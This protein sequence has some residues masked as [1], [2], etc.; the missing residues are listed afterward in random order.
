MMN[1]LLL[2]TAN[3]HRSRTSEDYFRSVNNKHK[4]Q[5]VGLSEK[6]CKQ[7]DTQRCSV[8][9]LDWADKVLVMEVMYVERITQ[10]TGELFLVVI[11]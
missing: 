9:M 6:Y 4:F 5:S 1:I 10:H 11:K 8:E 3:L 7:Y 2:C